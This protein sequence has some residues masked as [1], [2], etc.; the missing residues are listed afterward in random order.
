MQAVHAGQVDIHQDQVGLLAGRQ[1]VTDQRVRRRQQ[2]QVTV[3]ADDRFHQL[4]AIRIILDV[5]QRARPFGFG[6][7]GADLVAARGGPVGDFLFH[8]LVTDGYFD[9]EAAAD[10]L[11]AFETDP[12]AQLFDDLACDAEA[13]SAAVDLAEFVT[14]PL[15]GFEQLVLLIRRDTDTVVADADT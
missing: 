12:A 2:V 14:E 13:D 5:Q 7:V 15:E 10:I 3:L 6:A 4:H 11:L 9:P 8:L 1:V